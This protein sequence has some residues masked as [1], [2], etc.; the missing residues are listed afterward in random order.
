MQGGELFGVF[1]SGTVPCA[2]DGEGELREGR[3]AVGRGRRGR[4]GVGDDGYPGF[5]ERREGG[6]VRFRREVMVMMMLLL[7]CGRWTTET[8]SMLSASTSVG[9]RPRRSDS[10]SSNRAS[11]SEFKSTRDYFDSIFTPTGTAH[12]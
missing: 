10:L 3:G 5:G 12:D 2:R 6:L 9:L 4:G 1:E 8:T 11:L 7:Y